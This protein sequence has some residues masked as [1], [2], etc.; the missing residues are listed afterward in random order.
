MTAPLLSVRNLT[1][2]FPTRAGPVAVVDD[3]GFDLEAGE[4]LGI[5]GESGSGKSLTALAILRLIARPGR[6]AGGAIRFDGRDLLQQPESAMHGL[7][8]TAISMIFQE[9]MSS[10]NPV[11]TIG[12]QTEERPGR[13]RS[14]FSTW[15]RFRTRRGASTIIPISSPAACASAP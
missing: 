1:V 8:G 6:I 2:T 14:T 3:V 13:R 4:V 15:S 11:F 5:V 9:P 10:L 7:R 12:N